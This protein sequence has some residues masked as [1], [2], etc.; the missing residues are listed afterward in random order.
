MKIKNY[1][2]K[3]WTIKELKGMDD[4]YEVR[5]LTSTYNL[6][7]ADTE[8][9][10]LHIILD[11]AFC[12]TFAIVNKEERLGKA[13]VIDLRN[14]NKSY[15]E[16]VESILLSGK[17]LIFWNAKFDLHMLHNIGM[18]HL[19][20]HPKLKDAMIYAR[21]ANPAIP[22]KKG[23][24]DL[25]LKPY[26]VKHIDSDAKSYEREVAI[27]KREVALKRCKKLKEMGVKI[28]ELD[29]FLKDK[30]NSVED[31]PQEIQDILLDT[32]LNPDNYMN[33]P[34][35]V[36]KQYAAFDAIF[37][38]ENY[39]RD[40]PIV[41]KRDQIR[42]AEREEQLIPILWNMERTGFKLNVLYL[43]QAKATLKEYII[44]RRQELNDLVGQPLKVGQH[45]LIKEIFFD[46]FGIILESSD[47]DALS[48]IRGGKP[49][50]V[51]DIILE[52]RTLEKWYSTYICKWDKD[53]SRI[54]RVYTSF[55]QVNAVSGRF[56]C[57]FQ[58][59]PKEPIYKK[60]GTLLF[61][62]RRIV[63]VSGDEYD[64][65][66]LIDYAAEELRI[67]AL[68][69]MLIGKPDLNLCRAYLPVNCTERD[70]T[71]YLNEDPTVEWKPTDLHS[72][73]ALTAF[74]ELKVTDPNFSHYRKIG[75]STNF[76]CNY[77]A[78]KEALEKKPFRFPKEMAEKLYTA[79]TKAY[80][81]VMEYRN[82]VKE[83]LRYQNYVTDL[84]GRRFYDCPYHNATNYLIQGSAADLLKIKIIE[85][86][87][88]ITANNYKSRILC[89]IHDEIMFEIHKDEHDIVYE[90]KK[91]MEDVPNSP[92]PFSAEIS[93]SWTTWDAKKEI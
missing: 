67:Q 56:A 44:Q 47:E 27:A 55:K 82:Y 37:T 48:A 23:G 6:I 16:L 89:S 86:Q 18:T 41:E 59:F 30:I 81:N 19:I 66:C 54:D 28:G 65:L 87:N 84:F 36:L 15:L 17:E 52:L 75:K 90:F 4:L 45:E 88:F 32:S 73:T 74:P 50:E 12:L 35:N 11:K 5:K 69:T 60:D 68:Y 57:D 10:G 39:L 49:E 85:L 76:A 42:I 38:I 93:I 43:K 3:Q 1:Y 83:L 61:S 72:L 25:S 40:L 24:P 71:Y 78:T 29:K 26:S 22:T 51:A 80:P 7:A 13:Y 92:I 31:L 53:S 2:C 91:I 20:E 8:T 70:G 14:R 64:Q 63:S 33:I 9:S 34:W 46:R 21:L 58:Q 77:G 79:Y 62:P